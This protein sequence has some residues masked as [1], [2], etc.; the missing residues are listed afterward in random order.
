[1]EEILNRLGPRA[2]GLVFQRD[3]G[4]EWTESHLDQQHA[5]VRT[6]F[7]HSFE[8][9]GR[10]R[11]TFITANVRN[12]TGRSRSRCLHDH[13]SVELAFERLTALNLKRAATV[14][15]TVVGSKREAVVQVV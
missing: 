4:R 5:S 10:V 14:C 15:A 9:V 13:E 8:V 2:S 11:A 6:L 12:A 7:A 1:M 3:D